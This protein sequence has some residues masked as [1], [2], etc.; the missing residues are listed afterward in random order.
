MQKFFEKPRQVVFKFY[1]GE[2][3][4][5]CAGIAYH[6]EII[7]G[8]CGGIF[9]KFSEI[10]IEQELPWISLIEEIAPYEVYGEIEEMG[11]KRDK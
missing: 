3:Y 6:D 5:R 8:C 4:E 9:D 11:D 1:N 7:C 10:E 2:C